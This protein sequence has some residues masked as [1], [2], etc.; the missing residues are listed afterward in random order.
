MSRYQNCWPSPVFLQMSIKIYSSP[1]SLGPFPPMGEREAC[2]SAHFLPPPGEGCPQGQ[3][4]GFIKKC[5][6]FRNNYIYN[7]FIIRLLSPM[8][9]RILG[10]GYVNNSGDPPFFIPHKM[11]GLTENNHVY[12]FVAVLVFFLQK[13]QAFVLLQPLS[14]NKGSLVYHLIF[15]A[16]IGLLTPGV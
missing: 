2:N 3:K 5:F 9:V 15:C 10:D 11:Q 13:V 7:S 16:A 1:L 8:F 6:V 12:V 14:Y 4:G